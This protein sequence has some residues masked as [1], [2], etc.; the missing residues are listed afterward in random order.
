M[1]DSPICPML[2]GPCIGS[3][4]MAWTWSVVQLRSTMEQ[5]APGF[6][7]CALIAQYSISL[8]LQDFEDPAGCQP[9][10]EALAHIR[11]HER[12]YP[13]KMVKDERAAIE[14]RQHAAE[15]EQQRRNRQRYVYAL[16]AVNGGAIK[17]GCSQNPTARLSQ[18]QGSTPTTLQLLATMAGDYTTEKGF[19][20][21][22]AAHRVKGEWFNPTPEVLAVVDEIRNAP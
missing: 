14:A 4:C 17:I 9:A 2:R 11:E 12:A 16:Q 22:L 15:L 10:G 13:P 18:L 7:R 8:G 1:T 21:R 19:H 3:D 5:G 6:G 20:D